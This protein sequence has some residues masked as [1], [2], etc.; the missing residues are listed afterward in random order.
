ML[1]V[2]IFSTHFNFSGYTIM[3]TKM[4]ELIPMDYLHPPSESNINSCSKQLIQTLA[5]LTLMLPVPYIC[6]SK[7][8]SDEINSTQI[9]KMFCGIFWRRLF[10]HLYNNFSSFGAG[11]CVSKSSFKWMKNSPKQF[12]SIMVNSHY[13]HCLIHNGGSKIFKK[14][15][16][17]Q[18]RWRISSV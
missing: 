1:S 5:S 6:V 15:V 8:T 10:L 16:R 17:K 2:P 9:S 14:W 12:C 7:Q 13:R 18:K 11:N 4:T 3:S